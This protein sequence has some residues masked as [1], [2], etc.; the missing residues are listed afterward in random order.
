MIA[1]DEAVVYYLLNDPTLNEKL[2]IDIIIV[3][4]N[5]I[6]HKE[7]SGEILEEFYN[8]LD[9][10]TFNIS[11]GTVS[12]ISKGIFRTITNKIAGYPSSFPSS[13]SAS[14]V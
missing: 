10:I 1:R 8:E 12:S 6:I 4:K 3:T 11:K 5:D 13:S 2:T 7:V 14:S 9:I